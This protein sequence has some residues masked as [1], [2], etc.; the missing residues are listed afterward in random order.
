MAL[1]FGFNDNNDSYKEYGIDWLF[2]LSWELTK[3]KK[4]KYR[5]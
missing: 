1:A 5:T 4:D 2:L 3:T